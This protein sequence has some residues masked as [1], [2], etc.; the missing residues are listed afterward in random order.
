MSSFKRKSSGVAST[1]ASFSK[2]MNGNSAYA[3]FSDSLDIDDHCIIRDDDFRTDF[4]IL[5]YFLPYIL[6]K[7]HLGRVNYIS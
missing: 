6:P 4:I 3:A 5:F 7:L 1:L 2:A